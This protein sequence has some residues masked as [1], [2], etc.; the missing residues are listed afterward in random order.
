MLTQKR[1]LKEGW[2]IVRGSSVL[3]LVKRV[4]DTCSAM[5]TEQSQC[6]S[7]GTALKNHV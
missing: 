5:Q 1:G 3:L 4:M 6:I 7:S 2:S